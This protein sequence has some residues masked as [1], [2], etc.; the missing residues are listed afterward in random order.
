MNELDRLRQTFYE[1]CEELLGGLQNSLDLLADGAADPAER[2]QSVAA[3]FR[4]AH[5]I[6]GGG[7]AF[8]SERLVTFSHHMETV[9]DAVRSGSLDAGP[10]VVEAL[11]HA[12]DHLADLVAAE[13]DGLSLPCDHENTVAA[14]LC[15]LLGVTPAPM[16]EA[17]GSLDPV[18]AAMGADFEFPVIAADSAP[19]PSPAP[20]PEAPQAPPPRRWTISFAPNADVLRA[21]NQPLLVL[22]ALRALGPLSLTCHD[23][24]VPPLSALEMGE[25]Y[26]SWTAELTSDAPP[27][28]IAEPFAFVA[29]LC[30]PD[31]RADDG[32][33]V[34]FDDNGAMVTPNVSVDGT[35][36]LASSRPLP[37]KTSP[38]TPIVQPP[39]LSPAPPSPSPAEAAL[40]VVAPAGNGGKRA[41]SS[42]RVDVERIDRLVNMVGEL[43]ITQAMLA[44]QAQGLP[45]D[46]FPMLFQ[47]LEDLASHTRDLQESVMAI[48]AQ[49][50]KTAFARLPRLVRETAQTL[51]KKV[52]LLLVGEETEVDKSV[53]EGLA[54]P[55]MHLIRN[56][57][58]HG[59]EA[60][61]V[62]LAAGKPEEGTVTV[63]AE[64][65]SGRIVIQVFDD[66]AG[67]NLDAVRAKAIKQGLL[68][69]GAQPSDEDLHEML[70]QPGFSTV[71]L[72][73]NISGRGVGMDVVRSNVNALGGRI[74]VRSS[75]GRGTAFAM[76]LPL[77]L[78][79]MDGMLLRVGTHTYVLPIA[80]IV[81]SL[82]PLA[83][84]IHSLVGRGPVLSVRGHYVPLV[85][86]GE[87]FN[88]P[89]AQTQPAKTLVVLAEA[90]DG[91]KVALMVDSLV[92][93]QQ[94]VI[95]SL[96]QNFGQCEGISAA[97]ILGDGRVALILDVAGIRQMIG[98]RGRALRAGTA[99]GGQPSGQEDKA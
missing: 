38:K 61:E 45:E 7:G 18:A 4:A 42:I 99:A 58:D 68:P 29:T 1:E 90:E 81:E 73:S 31:I 44:Q 71:D 33:V 65:R 15:A 60:P 93:Q 89:G 16:A 83:K 64:H 50:V 86:L 39:A 55:L 57:I 67:I 37:P 47:G 3:A 53:V 70:F 87:L 26:L 85:C 19:V 48:R 49:P 17:A 77:T 78:A 20:A 40:A 76:T 34:V 97:T 35:V 82:K 21:G 54:D 28:V 30:P 46:R 9:L 36:Q 11:F 6:K 2:S 95:K 74:L 84:D 88:A 94:V 66:G 92:G 98:P 52:R 12:T 69:K 32:T 72:I 59:I 41:A 22:Q 51:N 80:N 96:E 25:C 91:G 8:G 75:K 10:A 62:R 23:Q 14:E 27:A 56:A 5:S 79:V 13:R 24:A 63:A 43:V